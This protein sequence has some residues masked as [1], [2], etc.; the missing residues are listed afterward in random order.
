MND[1][2]RDSRQLD[3]AAELLWSR[4]Q[5]RISVKRLEQAAA[6][7]VECGKE[8]LRE[9]C[10][11]ISEERGRLL[12]TQ[13]VEET[14]AGFLLTYVFYPESTEP[15]IF[16]ETRIAAG[17]TAPSLVA[18]SRGPSFDWH[19][20]EAE[21]LFGL[22]FEGHPRL[23]EFVLHEE[24]P[25]GVN[26]MRRSF[27]AK[28]WR[29]ERDSNASWRP[30]RALLEPG[31]FAMPI[32]PIFSDFAESSHFLLET[33]GEDVVRTIPRFF[34]KY[35][36]VEKIAE[37]QTIDRVLL[38]AE[39]FSGAS[40]FAHGLAFC[41]AVEAICEIEPPPRAKALRVLFAELERLRHHAASITGI[42]NSTALAIAT[43]Q[44]SLIEEELLRLTGEIVR[45][46]YFFG[47]IAL[48][49]VACD[50]DDAQARRLGDRVKE[51]GGRIGELHRLLRYSSSFLDRLE[52]VGVVS[53]EAALTY[54]LVGPIG[55]ASGLKR[56]VRKLRPY[57]IYD[58]VDFV[59]PTEQ[60]GDGYARLRV[61]FRE[62][63][64]SA[65]I[66][67]QTLSNLPTGHLV[68][69]PART[70]SGAALGAVEAP[71]GAAFHW[72]RLTEDGAV[73]RWRVTPP[74]FPNWH[75]FHLAAEKFA[76]QDF[77][78]ILA[79]FGLSNAECDR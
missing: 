78:I 30:P 54:G 43:S 17:E 31:S 9:F 23:G 33:I 37:G 76:F 34:Y 3:D 1:V 64:Q 39:R 38:L 24:W 22:R 13:V 40:A 18:L 75:G 53:P 44:A 27:S 49:G 58:G 77:P 47:V 79:T 26:P 50:L 55:R 63:E 36:G 21:D 62:A 32:G 48:G 52:E 5:G 72:V 6:L 7:K 45:H 2:A 57:A 42:C 25:E 68:A 35:R 28:A 59:A 67:S 29:G 11:W 8:D 74:S 65:L 60:E 10:E 19:E 12:A 51:I 69:G 61:F 4:W 70:R 56:D 41:Q 20:R 16:V 46:R 73:T 71:S 14:S 15:W 66:I